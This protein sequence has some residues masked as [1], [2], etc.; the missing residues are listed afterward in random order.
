MTLTD[1]LITLA[2]EVEMA[3]PIDWGMLAIS[4]DQAYELIAGSV[5]EQ[6]LLTDSDSRD[7]VMLS[8]VLKLTV[9]N[10]VLN[11]KLAQRNAL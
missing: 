11:L 9:E 6:Y 3:D 1:Q 2:K 5:L 4:E 8:V 7:I 10:F